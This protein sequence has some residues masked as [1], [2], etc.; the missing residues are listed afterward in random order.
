MFG[1]SFHFQQVQFMLQVDSIL[2]L[3]ELIIKTVHIQNCMS[4]FVSVMPISA[5]NG[6]GIAFLIF[7][8]LFF[9]LCSMH[10]FSFLS[11]LANS[12][13]NTQR[14]IRFKS[15]TCFHTEIVAADHT[16]YLPQSPCTDIWTSSC[17]TN[18]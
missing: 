10:I 11:W 15:F 9:L 2:M 6:T 5:V 8:F 17:S 3:L 12:L 7:W 1:F 14:R 16:C 13:A 18:Q 4:F